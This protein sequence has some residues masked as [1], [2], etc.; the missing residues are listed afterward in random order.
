MQSFQ[1]PANKMVMLLEFH[2][3]SPNKMVTSA[4]FQST[5]P[6]KIALPTAAATEH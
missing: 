2:S 3:F 6:N 4:K 1:L 5:T